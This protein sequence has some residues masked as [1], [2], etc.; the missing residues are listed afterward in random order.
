MDKPDDEPRFTMLETLREYALEQLAAS[1]EAGT[2]GQQHATYY[3][4]L[5]EA[6]APKI[7]GGEQQRWLGELE[8]E[9]DNLR[10]AREWFKDQANGI[11]QEGRQG[12]ALLWFCYF[13][14]H[15]SECRTWS[16]ELLARTGVEQRTPIRAGALFRL[17]VLAWLQGDYRLGRV[18]LDES[19]AIWRALGEQRGLAHALA[20]LGALFSNQ[21]EFGLSQ[22]YLDESI[23]IFR[24]VQDLWGLVV[25]MNSLGGIWASNGINTAGPIGRL[26]LWWRRPDLHRPASI[27][28]YS[29]ELSRRRQANEA[30]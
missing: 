11:E 30:R 6:I 18:H 24:D 14:S 2:I 12:N 20:F 23:A 7:V 19:V 4:A 26:S 3:L 21:G 15:W 1:G 13:R 28:Y 29:V 9:Y 17:G 22:A 10:A 8:I 5:A 16:D 25:P 27:S